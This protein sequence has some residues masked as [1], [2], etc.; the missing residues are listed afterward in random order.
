MEAH[1][2]PHASDSLDPQVQTISSEVDQT[3][4]SSEPTAFIRTTMTTSRQLSTVSDADS[5]I[6]SAPSSLSPQPTC[7]PNS[8]EVLRAHAHQHQHLQ[9]LRDE[10]QLVEIKMELDRMQTKYD[11]LSADYGKAKEQIDELEQE[12]MEVSIRGR[13]VARRYSLFHFVLEPR[14]LMNV[15]FCFVFRRR[16]CLARERN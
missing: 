13:T 14:A 6:S 5:A 8:P 9:S 11:L 15:L 3:S 4:S 12:L 2:E 7:C 10:S 16:R 1:I